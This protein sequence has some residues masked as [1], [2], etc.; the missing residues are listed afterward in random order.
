LSAKRRCKERSSFCVSCP[1]SGVSVFLDFYRR[2]GEQMDGWNYTERAPK[3]CAKLGICLMLI[4]YGTISGLCAQIGWE[5]REKKKTCSPQHLAS[6]LSASGPPPP[7]AKPQLLTMQP[8]SR[9]R[10]PL[11]RV[12]IRIPKVRQPPAQHHGSVQADANSRAVALAAVH[13]RR[14]GVDGLGFRVAQLFSFS[15]LCVCVRERE[16]EGRGRSDEP[17]ASASRS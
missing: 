9:P 16:R 17:G 14:R 3:A 11:L 6:D 7:H 4:N 12:H 10:L 5:R 1:G 2:P 15:Q 13:P 8:G